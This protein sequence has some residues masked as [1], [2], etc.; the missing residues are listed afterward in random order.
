MVICIQS[1]SG[2]VTLRPE[3][4]LL[5]VLFVQDVVAS[6]WWSRFT[7]GW[8]HGHDCAVAVQREKKNPARNKDRFCGERS[9]CGSCLVIGRWPAPRAYK[10]CCEW[11]KGLAQQLEPRVCS[12]SASLGS[13]FGVSRPRKRLRGTHVQ[14][15][16]GIASFY[17]AALCVCAR[18]TLHFLLR[19]SEGVEVTSPSCLQSPHIFYLSLSLPPSCIS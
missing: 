16:S 14:V 8:R 10:S 7:V 13:C 15:T 5:S 2:H 1:A 3:T 17:A 12:C 19:G 4:E 18:S 6:W 11:L 9:C